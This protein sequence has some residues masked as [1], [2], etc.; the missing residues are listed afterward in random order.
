VTLLSPP[1]Y[2]QA[3]VYS[4]LLDRM[5][6]NTVPTLRDFGQAHRARQGF[7]PSRVPTFSVVS[8]MTVAISA[9]AG[10]IANTFIA[11]GG[12]YKFSNPSALQVV[13][14]G[15][16]PTLNRHDIVGFQ[17]QD[18]FYDSSGQNQA[19]PTVVQGVNSAGTPTDPAMPASF[20]PVYRAVIAAGS[21]SPTL[22]SLIQRTTHDGGLLPIA[23]DSERSALGTPHAGFPILRTDQYG[24]VQMWTGS[25]WVSA[26]NPP[27]MHLRQTTVQSIPNATFTDI[28]FQT[29]DLDNFNSHSAGTP[30]RFISQREGVYVFAGGGT[31]ASS[32]AGARAARWAANGAAVPGGQNQGSQGSVTNWVGAPTIMRRMVV[33]DFMTLQA[34]QSSGGA[35]NTNVTGENQWTMSAWWIAP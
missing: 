18:N 12:D 7:Y 10:L 20:V 25:T 23:S 32:V 17:V 11:D 9:C 22:Q 30:T 13:H 34:Y 3:G 29:E 26:P 6:I 33:G 8:G 21:T 24:T 19:I 1:G 4:A 2:L 5:Y 28:S 27:Y 35:L 16:S 14:A 31:F 15:S